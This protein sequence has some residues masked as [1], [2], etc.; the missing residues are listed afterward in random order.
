MEQLHEEENKLK[1]ANL[2]AQININKY[3]AK[4]YKSYRAAIDKTRSKP[5]K[6]PSK[7]KTMLSEPA[8]SGHNVSK[9]E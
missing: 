4:L 1:D 3:M 8:K 6:S 9:H 7:T 2:K 5:H